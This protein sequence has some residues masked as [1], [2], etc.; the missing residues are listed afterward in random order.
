LK[1]A[2]SMDKLIVW[3]TVCVAAVLFL[4]LGLLL[5]YLADKYF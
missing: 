5:A 2:V 1:E 4:P 3:L